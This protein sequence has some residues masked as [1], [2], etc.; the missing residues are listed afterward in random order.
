M[1]PFLAWLL[2][3]MLLFA[4]APLAVA[5]DEDEEEPASREPK[6]TCES[7]N[8]CWHF[9][10]APTTPADQPCWCPKCT[11][12][13]PHDGKTVPKGW[14]PQCFQ[15]KSLD[16]FLRRHSASWKITCTECLANKDCCDA[17][18]QVRC[19]AC[20][21]GDAK[22]PLAKDCY[23]KDA[24]GSAAERLAVELKVFDRKKPVCMFSRRFYVVTD[25]QHVQIRTQ[26]GG[27]RYVDA[28]EYGHIVL[29][30]AEKAYRQ[31]DEAFKGRITLMRPMGIFLPQDD[32]TA[33]SVREAYFRNKNAPM[34]YSSYAG[35]AE[36]MISQGFSLNGLCVSFQQCSKDDNQLH[37][38]M[39]HLMGNIL[40]TCWIKA[41]GDNK[42]MPRWAF[43]GAA[44][45]LGRGA[46]NLGDEAWYCIG[47]DKKVSGSAKGWMPDLVDSAAKGKFGPIQELFEKSDLGQLSH[48]DH[49]RAWG[50]FEL[51]MAEWRD[52]F[53]EMLAEVRRETSIRE[54]FQKHMGC[55][56]EEF[57]QRFVDRL[58]G[59]TKS[60]S[61]S[62]YHSDA[63]L[64][65]E[66][67][68]RIE[69]DPPVAAAK[70]RKLES[71]ADPNVVK[72][73]VDVLG[74][75]QS[76]LVRETAL[77]VLRKVKDEP[78]RRAIWE[79][80]LAQGERGCRVYAARLC[81]ELRI[82][83][84]KD[85]LRK[86]LD[87][88]WWQAKCEAALALA[89]I[90]DFDS[91]ARMREL[92]EKGGPKIRIAAM[93][94][95]AMFE[96]EVNES[97][98]PVIAANLTHGNWQVRVAACQNLRKIGNYAAVDALIARF[99]QEA[100]RLADEILKTLRWLTN[101]DFG[102]KPNLWAKW[103]EREGGRVKQQRKFDPKPKVDPNLRY[104][105]QD[106]PK[107][108]GVE[109]F[110]HRVGFVLD[111]SRST[112]RLFNPDKSTQLLLHRKYEPGSTIFQIAREEVAES[113]KALDPRSFF[114]VIAFGTSVRKWERTMVA[115]T[116]SNK[117]RAGGFVRS[118]D[119][120]GETNFHGALSAALDLDETSMASDDLR[121]TLDTMV[122]LTDGTPTQGDLT[123]PDQLVSWYAELNRYFRV[124]TH[125]YAFGRLE[126]DVKLLTRI[127]EGSGGTFTQLFEEN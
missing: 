111:T 127:A 60:I 95:L 122:F 69:D 98:V 14:N 9:L 76:D 96:T 123:A 45:W 75:T 89:A 15:S 101:E 44:H 87:D 3:T 63:P 43:E 67:D 104:G 20:A 13:H 90:K 77:G 51:C 66:F 125:T 71:V 102:N 19:P 62:R 117:D 94:A 52:P 74:R 68:L 39:R 56:P 8:A 126:V 18:N 91:Q 49:K 10:R 53:V 64:A 25:M 97:C 28:H 118:Y 50:I 124:R 48:A 120:E 105:N 54:A 24:R 31:F 2:L 65:G 30:R 29:E 26:G 11:S 70:L 83:E 81:R 103:W 32:R 17:K 88:G 21:E 85:A 55:T 34:I 93:D 113:V 12:D 58:L 121:D 107:Y 41:K 114:N 112:N 5:Q 35:P 40:V 47:E 99:E 36:S 6:C 73:I 27:F 61:E 37:Q 79:H 92:V 38:S 86:Q 1:K 16:C 115:A 59:L 4:P 22:D 46:R 57:Q 116:P 80:G 33:T 78:C 106:T 23:G 42:S 72:R 7:R 82:V 100:G 84:A 110:A 108:Y 119:A 109:L